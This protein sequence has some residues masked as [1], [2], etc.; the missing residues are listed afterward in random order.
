MLRHKIKC[1][2]LLLRHKIRSLWAC[3]L[4]E[5][6][7][8]LLKK[9]MKMEDLV[10]LEVLTIKRMLE[11]INPLIILKLLKWLD[12]S[13]KRIKMTNSFLQRRIQQHN[14]LF[15][16]LVNQGHLVCHPL[17]C[18]SQ[19][20]PL[21]L[22]KPLKCLMLGMMRKRKK[23]CS[24]LSRNRRLHQDFHLHL[25]HLNR[26]SNLLTYSRMRTK[27][28]RKSQDLLSSLKHHWHH[29]SHSLA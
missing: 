20:Y 23:V 4:K 17:Q 5:V 9:T 8:S 29:L 26:K 24:Q 10:S 11:D 28:M 14:H 16:R 2:W 27:T 25:S 19:T 21:H 18:L 3:Q 15:L 22:N 1:K 7:Y 12:S 6:V 13:M